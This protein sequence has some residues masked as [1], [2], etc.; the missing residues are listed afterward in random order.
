MTIRIRTK[1]DFFLW[2]ISTYTYSYTHSYTAGHK[3]KLLNSK[4]HG[5]FFI[6][7]FFRRRT[8]WS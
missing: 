6:F 7:F 4:Q 3:F 5:T 8:S 2:L 1:S